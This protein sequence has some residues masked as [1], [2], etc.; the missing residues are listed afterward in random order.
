MEIFKAIFQNCGD[1]VM[2]V[3]HQSHVVYTNAQARSLLSV[4]P[5]LLTALELA[6][7]T[8]CELWEIC[9]QQPQ[10]STDSL[11]AAVLSAAPE[12]H[13]EFILH[14]SSAKDETWLAITGHSFALPNHD[15]QGGL[16]LLR[17]AGHQAALT[18]NLANK[19]HHDE[20]TG[21]VNRTIFM[22]RI[23]HA[24]TKVG[25]DKSTFIAVLCLDVMRLKAVN[26]SFGYAAGD[27]LLVEIAHRL[28]QNLRREDTFSRLGGDEFT[29]L[30]EEVSS[31]SEV[32]AIADTLYQ[33]LMAPFKIADYEINVGVNIGI[34]L[35]SHQTPNADTLLR[36]ADLAMNEAKARFEERYCVFEDDMAAV[37]DN[38][39]YLEMSLRRAIKNNEFYLVYQPIFLV[40]THAVIGVESLVRWQHPTRGTISPAQFIPLAE[41]TGLIIPLGWW[42]LEESCRQLKEWQ[43]TIPGAENLFVS[44]NM[45]S[46]QFAQR[47]LL[48]GIKHILHKTGL[49]PKFLKIEMTES[50]LIENSDSIIEILASI[51]ELGI[52]LSVDDFGTGYSS[53]SYLH[54]FTVD[55]LKI[56]R[57]FLENADSDFEKL[58]I[59]QSV[60]RLAWN[61][62]LEVVAEGIETRRHLAQ[63]KALR[64]ESGQGFLFSKP[65]RSHEMNQLLQESIEN[66]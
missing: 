47:D 48:E 23:H 20:L 61:L 8:G 33:E 26:D 49:S 2:V 15:F 3:D 11:L 32:L 40:R 24:L 56:D 63:V 29:V 37:A 39:L 66:E 12:Q 21:L 34:S 43:E 18:A 50:V 42:V 54:Q 60:V 38:S 31:Y 5:M 28:K 65:L 35:G 14:C 58:E 41:K 62:G 64:C 30:L 17:D 53:L 16:L 57:S 52:K 22:D 25:D 51:R 36:Q 27:R 45:S 1:A 59:L 6:D 46:R 10:K 13:R 55:T 7:H 4:S 44:V 19:S 9:H